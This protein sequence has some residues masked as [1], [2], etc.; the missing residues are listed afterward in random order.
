MRIIKKINKIFG[1]IFFNFYSPC[2]SKK[3][4]ACQPPFFESARINQKHSLP[5]GVKTPP[6]V[7]VYVV[8]PDVPTVAGVAV[9]V[10]VAG[11]HAAVK[12]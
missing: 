9:N 8:V 11:P 6:V 10:Y 4:G 1:N 2:T 12:L 7:I 5:Y 3:K